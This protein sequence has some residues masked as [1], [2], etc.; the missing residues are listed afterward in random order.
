MPSIANDVDQQL[1]GARL[2]VLIV[3]AGIAGATLGALLRRHGASAAIVEREHDAGTRGYMLAIT[4]LGGRVFNALGLRDAYLAAS[5]PVARYVMHGCGGRPLNS[6]PLAQIV[7]R[8]GEYR[9]VERGPLLAL[10]RGAAGAIRYGATVAAI[11]D[12]PADHRGGGQARVRFSDGSET[13][14]DLVVA[15][16]GIHSATRGLVLRPDEVHPRD[17]GWSGFVGWTETVNGEADTYRELWAAG[18]GIGLYPVPS[19]TGLFLCGPRERIERMDPRAYVTELAGRRLPEPFAGALARITEL[20]SGHPWK[21]A[22]R[23]ADV[24]WRGRTVLLGDAAAAFLPTAGIGA[25]VAMDS[26]AA[27]ADELSRA[28]PSRLAY[29]LSLYE[30]RQRRRVERAQTGSRYLA[31]VMFM[32][33]PTLARLRD[34]AVPFYSRDRLA[35]DVGKLMEGA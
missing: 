28:D 26:A 19:R 34:A 14:V 22:D 35:D 16:D 7:D 1:G 20:E 23:R 9:G 21:M 2:R 32:R 24:W 30:R 27:L 3:G 33:S 17:V 12:E 15:A 29:A 5:I 18:W 6:Y 31:H 25:S 13:A 4:P 11:T 8:Y 10:L